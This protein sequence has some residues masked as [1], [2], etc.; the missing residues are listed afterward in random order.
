VSGETLRT[1]VSVEIAEEA[2][3][4]VAAILE[5]LRRAGT[6]SMK[7]VDQRNFHLTI[8]FLGP[9]QREHLPRLSEALREVASRTVPFELELA[10][11]GA[12]PNLRRPRVIWLGV[13]AGTEVLASLAGRAEE[14]CAAL[15]WAREEKPYR[16]H[17]TLARAREARRGARG[18]T[19]ASMPSAGLLQA[20]ELERDSRAGVTPVH[21]LVLMESQLHPHGPTYTVVDS[22]P[23]G[24]I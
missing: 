24:A 23:F 15:G 12:F 8:K 19:G 2:A 7:W 20:L 1:F 22:F 10:G 4:Q 5:R 6:A 17:L 18:H 16:A 11:V 13:S 21:R 9:T 3:G 14:A